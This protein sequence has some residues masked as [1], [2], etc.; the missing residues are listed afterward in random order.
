[1]ICAIRQF[2]QSL[3]CAA[4]WG[5]RPR[6]GA[7]LAPPVKRLDVA[8]E[9]SDLTVE[10]L[11]GDVFRRRRFG[12]RRFGPRWSDWIRVV[13]NFQIFALAVLQVRGAKTFGQIV[14][15]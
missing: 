14:F 15:P 9:R 1:M 13:A 7:D 10:R 12:P 5:A 11:H 4:P 6:W 8:P 2:A 3:I